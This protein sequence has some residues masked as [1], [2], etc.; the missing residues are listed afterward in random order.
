MYEYI[1]TSPPLIFSPNPSI[2]FLSIMYLIDHLNAQEVT[3]HV[4]FT[5]FG[6]SE[7]CPLI[8]Y[9]L[10]LCIYDAGNCNGLINC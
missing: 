6:I 4:Q 5:A 10:A 2:S 7:T 1:R 8:F 3:N 9:Y